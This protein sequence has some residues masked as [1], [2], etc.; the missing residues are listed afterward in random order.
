MKKQ[1]FILFVFLMPHF[2]CLNGYEV[3]GDGE[4]HDMNNIYEIKPYE[5]SKSQKE[6]YT[7]ILGSATNYGA[8][9][10]KI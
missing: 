7:Y 8:V 10:N 2:A 4:R 9:F 6:H 5:V 1:L 3:S